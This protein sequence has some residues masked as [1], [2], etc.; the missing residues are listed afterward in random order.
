MHTSAQV[1]EKS[2]QKMLH[3][4][5]YSCH[6]PMENRPDH[7][8]TPCP[9]SLGE[10]FH[11]IWWSLFLHLD[12]SKTAP[13]HPPT[14]LSNRSASG[15]Y[16]G[17]MP[18]WLYRVSR[19]GYHRLIPQRAYS[20]VEKSTSSRPRLW[21]SSKEPACQC[22]RHRF[23][24]WVGKIPWR[25]KWQPI[26]VFLSGQSFGQM[27]LAGYSPWGHKRVRHDW[28]IKQQQQ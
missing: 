17:Q 18:Y 13:I 28:V 7:S 2:S 25:G 20:F 12:F 1:G 21:L 22:R 5:L 26:L 11:F 6:T 27:N 4:H 19:N 3:L 10:V 16:L 15:A 23:D 9:T 24:P 14:H 8:Y